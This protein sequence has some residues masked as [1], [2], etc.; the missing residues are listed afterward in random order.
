MLS[1][2]LYCHEKKRI[3]IFMLLILS[4]LYLIFAKKWIHVYNLRNMRQ[5]QMFWI[6]QLMFINLKKC[7][8]LISNEYN[9]G[10]FNFL[11]EISYH[12]LKKYFRF[13]FIFKIKSRWY[14]CSVYFVRRIR[15]I[16]H[17]VSKSGCWA[18]HFVCSF[19]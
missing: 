3:H 10:N 16:K 12:Y 7:N 11:C 15:G 1:K 17:T 18:M 2:L 13:I 6:W 14:V 9:K 8:L 4:W 5:S 19:I